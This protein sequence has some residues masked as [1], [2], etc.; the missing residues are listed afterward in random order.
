MIPLI[1]LLLVSGL[2]QLVAAKDVYLEWNITWVNAAPDGYERPVIGINN[3][4]PC[5]QVDVNV[6]DRLIVDVT[7]FLGNQSTAI[8]WHGLHQYTTGTMDGDAFV[9]QCPVPPGSTIRYDFTVSPQVNW[10][11]PHLNTLLTHTYYS[12]STNPV[13]IGIILT[14][15]DSIPMACVAH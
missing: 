9:T 8:H 6:G 13:P 15:W 2:G 1:A 11:L 7:N 3:E 14:T 10:L 5:P 4:W 12:S